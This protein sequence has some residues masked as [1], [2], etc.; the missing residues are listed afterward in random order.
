[1]RL[2]SGAVATIDANLYLNDVKYLASDQLKGRLT[3]SPELQKAAAF[4]AGQFREFGL[5]PVHGKAYY[6]PFQA[7]TGARLGTANRLRM[8]GAGQR[9]VALFR[10]LHAPLL[11]LGRQG[12]GGSGFRGLRHH[13]G[14]PALRRL[15]RPGC[16][17]QT[18]PDSAPRTAGSRRAQRLRRQTTHRPRALPAKLPTPRCTARRA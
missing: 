1:M 15:R 12:D 3:G 18:G 4:I 17:G 7:L 5:Q 8:S 14:R 13:R 16:E 2:A 6:Q 9:R 11:F 10:G